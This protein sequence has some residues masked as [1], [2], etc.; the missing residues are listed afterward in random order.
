MPQ[1]IC[2]LCCD[3]IN[4]FHNFREMCYA[5]DKQTRKLLGLKAPPGPP[6]DNSKE[7]SKSLEMCRDAEELTDSGNAVDITINR[8]RRINGQEEDNH[9]ATIDPSGRKDIDT[10]NKKICTTPRVSLPLISGR[11]R[12]RH[13]K[14][15]NYRNMVLRNDFW[16]YGHKDED[17]R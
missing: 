11:G 9:P 1:S 15:K 2:L 12:R 10:S 3:K 7:N 14:N 8:K 17:E 4:D 13:R 6:T 16:Y 5:T